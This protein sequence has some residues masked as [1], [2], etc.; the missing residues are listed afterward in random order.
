MSTKNKSDQFKRADGE[1][2]A[3]IQ[4]FD[5]YKT[6]IGPIEQWPENLMITVNLLLDSKFPMFLWWGPEKIQLY[7]DAYR[8]ILGTS[9]TGKHPLALGQRAEDSWGEIWPTISPLINGVF[10]TGEAV[11][12]EDQLIPI[13]REGHL[14]DIYWTFSYSPVRAE[15]GSTAGLLVVCTETTSY[16]QAI[17]RQETLKNIS[18][19]QKRSK[20]QSNTCAYFLNELG[21]NPNDIP[22]AIILLANPY[23]KLTYAGSKG[24]PF[25]KKIIQRFLNNITV[26]EAYRERN[27]LALNGLTSAIEE[28]LCPVCREPVNQAYV[29]PLF[30]SDH[31]EVSG[32]LILG[33]S[34]RKHLDSDYLSFMTL[35]ADSLSASLNQI[36]EINAQLTE[37]KM[38]Q[39]SQ[40]R[41]QHII[42]RSP[43]AMAIFR[44]SNFRIELANKKMLDYW[45]RKEAEVTN[46]PLFAVLPESSGQQFE[47]LLHK[48]LNNGAQDAMEIPMSI[49]RNGKLEKTWINF[50]S[51]QLLDPEGK[52]NGIMIVCM[53]V[54]GQVNNRKQLESVILELQLSEQR[55]RAMVEQAPVAIAV[56]KGRQLIIESANEMILS[57]WGKTANIINKPLI[58]ALPELKDQI[59]L[60]LLDDVY[61]S[62][63]PF[64]GYDQIAR[65]NHNGKSKDLY[66]NF[67]Y[68]KIQVTSNASRIIVVATDVTELMLA[69][70]ELEAAYEQIRL[71][72]EA[73]QLGTFDMDIPRGTMIWDDR[74]R[75]LFG[76][77]H[78]DT[79]TYEDDFLPGLHK[80]DRERVSG[81]INR[82]FNNSN[83]GD[84][85]VEYRTIGVEDKKLRWVR[86]K[87]KVLFDSQGK[88]LRFIGSVLEITKQKEEEQRKNDF[89]G[90]V[91]HELKTPLT[92]LKAN[93]QL[94]LLK[95]KKKEDDSSITA[96]EKVEQQINKMSTM[97]NGFLNIS[98]LESSVLQIHKED[99]YLNELLNDITEETKHLD[100]QHIITLENCGTASISADR[101]KIG[102]VISN[103]LSNAIK[104]SPQGKVIA[105]HCKEAADK[106]QISVQDQGIGIDQ[107]EM[108]RIFERYYRVENSQTLHISGFGIGLYMCAEIIKAHQGKIWGE[109]EPGEGSTFF[110]TLPLN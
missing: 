79:V 19:S 1:M 46:R 16:V 32:T 43:V 50:T 5:W 84:Y 35:I 12:L 71:S 48:T 106:V 81:L 94:L 93:V 24:I 45:D 41:L 44:D 54:T 73:A 7:N 60:R 90:M 38:A 65:L 110:V 8:A 47:E 89:I 77:S 72:K 49:I 103:L 80:D 11:Y 42:S 20:T 100:H 99:F 101:N 62:G 76:I 26:Q 53:E 29:F 85:D 18:F 66:F 95:A 6:A 31:L 4:T 33:I 28:I 74:C 86:A 57:L 30:H 9:D 10:E 64:H 23:G 78:H 37:K 69:R 51:E 13:Y 88:P 27:P 109:S 15:D 40:E 105:V 68:Q 34:P 108:D 58:Q 104:Y 3:R 22:F 96:L 56:F 92:L 83:N 75:I 14:D 25:S 36:S 59:F 107:N 63:S 98:H 21:K 52:V 82:L 102:Y 87:G 67:L 91:S 39:F 55:F 70:K 97:I 61:T 17:R 2:S